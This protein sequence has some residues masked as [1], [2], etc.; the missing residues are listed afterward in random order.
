MPKPS[1]SPTRMEISA[2]ACATRQV[3][4][5]EAGTS[6]SNSFM[7]HGNIFM[8]VAAM[9]FRAHDPAGR[10][11]R[12]TGQGCNVISRRLKRLPGS[13]A[14]AALISLSGVHLDT[15]TETFVGPDMWS[16][17]ASEARHA[18][19]RGTAPVSQSA[20]AAPLCGALIGWQ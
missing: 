3:E 19:Y 13:Q 8:I 18:Q 12:Q 17:V 9:S 20:V 6:D 2:W 1:L 16:A 15:A 7:L 11:N 4:R 14:F 5:C 10:R